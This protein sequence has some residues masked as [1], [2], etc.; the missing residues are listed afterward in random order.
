MFRLSMPGTRVLLVGTGAHGEES[1]LSPV[2]AVAATLS[3]LGQAMVERCGL[4][5]DNLTVLPDPANPT[6][7]GNAVAEATEQARGVLWFHFVGHGLVGPSSELYLATS[8]TDRR[9]GWF[10]HTALAYTAVRECLLQTGARSVVV[11]LDCCFSGRAVGFLGDDIGPGADLARVHG[12]FVLAAAAREGL[13][14]AVEG[15]AHTAFTGALIDLLREGDEEGPRQLTLRDATRYLDR[16]LRE[17]GFPPPSHGASGW[18]EDL[19]LCVNPSYRPAPA[20]A[21]RPVTAGGVPQVCPYPGMRS[22]GP[23]ESQWFFGRERLTGEL[24]ARMAECVHGTLPLVV[25][26]PSGAGKS[27]LL[28]AGL[29]PALAMSDSPVT[30]SAT[31]PRVL[32]TPTESPLTRLS[33]RLAWTV[34][35]PLTV[36]VRQLAEDPLLLVDEIRALLRDR[37]QGDRI[38]GARLVLVVDQLEE[39]FTECAD[40]RE[41]EA[42]LRALCA[43]AEGGGG[44]PPALVVLGL[45]GDFFGHLTAYPALQPALRAPF[46]VG[47]MRPSELRSAIE[48]PALPAGIVLQPGLVDVI[49]RDLGVTDGP[50]AAHYEPGALPLLAQALRATWQEREGHTLTL[51]GYE[52]IGGIHGAIATAAED[53]YRELGPAGQETGRRLLLSM[54]RIDDRGEHTRRLVER[55]Q[56]VA[57]YEDPSAAAEAL[58]AMARARLVT[59]DEKHVQ[60]THEILLRHWPLLR[61]WISADHKDLL[62]LQQLT[63]AAQAWHDDGRRSSDLYEDHRLEAVVAWLDTGGPHGRTEPL[64]NEFLRASK[65]REAEKRQA[66]RR[67][68]RWLHRTV[69]IL[70][71]LVLLAATTTVVAFLSR[72]EATKQRNQ[73]LSQSVAGESASLRGSDSALAAQLGLAAYR[74]APTLAARS[75]LLGAFS[76]S[77]ATRLPGHRHGSEWVAFSPDGRVLA[78]SGGD[79]SARLWDMTDPYHPRDQAELRGHQGTVIA[80]SFSPDGRT[81]ATAGGDRTTRLWDVRD[82]R[83]PKGLATLREHTDGV[84]SVA[85]SPDGRLMA[86]ASFDRTARL[87]DVTDLTNPRPRGVLRG[88]ADG[89]FKIAFSPAGHWVATASLDHTARLWNIDDPE[90][91]RAG[92][93]L[94]GHTKGLFQASFSPDAKLLAT[95]ALDGT[96]RLWDVSDP[97]HPRPRAQIDGPSGGLRTVTFSPHGDTLAAAGYDNVVRLWNVT[98]PDHPGLPVVLE[99][100]ADVVRSVAYSPDGR[101]LASA[102][103]DD[104]IRVW[105]LTGPTPFAHGDK[106]SAVF[107]APDGRSVMSAGYDRRLRLWDASAPNGRAFLLDGH[108]DGV[109][110]A[111]L[112][113]RGT[114]LATGSFDKSARLW[115]LSDQ[116]HPVPAGVLTG[117]TGIVNSVAFAP[118]DRTLATASFDGTARLWDV[119]D[120]R[121]PRALPV[122]RGHTGDVYAV[123]Y[124]PDGR[125][126]ATASTDQT[127][128]LWDVSSPDHPRHLT[129]LKGHTDAVNAVGFSPDGRILASSGDDRTARLWDVSQPDRPRSLAVLTGH[130]DGVNAVAFSPDGQTLAT[131]SDDRTTR[132]WNI[133]RPEHP[134]EQALLNGHTDKVVAVRFSPDGH[135]LVTGSYDNTARLWETDPRRVAER[136]CSVAVPPITRKQW[137]HYFPGVDYTPPCS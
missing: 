67:R 7:L 90:H 111:E 64:V 12:G 69:A 118:D 131:A 108:K 127:V 21:P 59:L 23:G 20:P 100:H 80:V 88:H 77:Y 74:L 26:G 82:P 24:T 28:G 68:T 9:K 34:G 107:F 129:V 15:A 57:G 62:T 112:S 65:A 18:V 17:R 40:E 122:L 45:R 133:S 73:A 123:A 5:E 136:V 134:E 50:E 31:W 84:A 115:D 94:T 86:T 91:P 75:G 32:L 56:L 87:W 37:N 6:E 36:S 35:R 103:K 39:V 14:L 61:Q 98:D 30:G 63:A 47:A 124:S 110:A 102:A 1:G 29:L 19:V 8:A 125:V 92:E 89:L 95:A 43:V 85:F 119:T 25:V 22:F 16:V 93:T 42:Y 38:A 51:E 60:I 52:R 4:A 104:A 33:A 27:S 49:L 105:S 70:T 116:S 55:E 117:H 76:P 54:V 126:V 78:T 11:V 101:F 121:R 120:I 44:E 66:E 106:V 130:T 113:H 46:P 114:A 97:E 109:I 99:G 79:G 41:R 48:S 2:P 53:V 71:G 132:L 10:A 135:T 128:R 81:L 96:A 72:Q 83:H 58:D 3:D 137:S 13:A